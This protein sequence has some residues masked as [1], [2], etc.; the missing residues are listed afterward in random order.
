MDSIESKNTE[1]DYVE[2]SLSK[3]ELEEDDV[4]DEE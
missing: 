1:E 2:M 3:C 4:S